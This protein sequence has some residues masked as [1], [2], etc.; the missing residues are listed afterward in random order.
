MYDFDKLDSMEL[1]EVDFIFNSCHQNHLEELDNNMAKQVCCF[2]VPANLVTS[3]ID[4]SSNDTKEQ[5]DM[6]S[7][8]YHVLT[9]MEIVEDAINNWEHNPDAGNFARDV[10]KTVLSTPICY[11]CIFAEP[12]SETLEGV[13]Y[14]CNFRGCACKPND[15]C[16]AFENKINF[17][18]ENNNEKREDE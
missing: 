12:L 4:M 5:I 13:L 17:E 11:H 6:S 16:H 14:F 7:N 1:R 9:P 2:S 10:L 3:K 15:R 8:G 18:E